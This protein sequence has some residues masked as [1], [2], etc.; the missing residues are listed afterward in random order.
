MLSILKDTTKETLA[1]ITDEKR[2]R[3]TA[4]SVRR[5]RKLERKRQLRED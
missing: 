4:E 5:V 3:E 2:V 1:A